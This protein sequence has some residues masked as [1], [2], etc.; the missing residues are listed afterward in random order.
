MTTAPGPATTLAGIA[1]DSLDT[2]WAPFLARLDGL[3]EDEYQWEPVPG[4]WTVR[5]SDDG[6]WAADWADPDPDPA[7]VTTIGGRCWHVAVDALDSYSARQ[8]GRTGTGLTGT[9]WVG[10][11]QEAR[12]LL[13]AAWAVFR[14]G[15]ATWDDQ[16]LLAPLGARWGGFARHSHLHLVLHAERE[17]VHHGAEIALLRDLYRSRADA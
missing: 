11:W 10:S 6:G 12:P 14:A 4:G 7:P 2:A 16:R 9:A 3:T 8:F 15:V 5:T 1:L 13:D 17:V